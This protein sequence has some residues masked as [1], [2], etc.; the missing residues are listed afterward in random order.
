MTTET[1]V[2]QAKAD[3][4]MNKALGDLVG[5]YPAL[6]CSLGDRLGL[7]KD[8][9]ANGP[10]TSEELAARTGVQERYAREWLSALTCAGY[11]EYDPATSRFSLPPEHAPMLAEE[12]GPAFFGGAYAM[13]PIQMGMFEELATAFRVGGG[14]TQAAYGDAF[15]DSWQRFSA[16]WFEHL[17][18][19]VWLPALPGAQERL[20]QGCVLADV[21]CGQGRALI[22]LAQSFPRSRFVGYDTYQP[23]VAQATARAEGAGV[24]ERVS[25]IHLDAAQGLPEQYDVIATFDVV[26]DAADPRGLLRAIHGAL[27]PDGTYLCLEVNCADRLEDN[28]GPLGAA[29]YSSSLIYCMTTS[30]AAGGEGLGSMGLPESRLRELCL[31]AGF[32]SVRLVP[33]EN[34]FNNLYEI[35]P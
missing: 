21:G 32:S 5:A 17:L 14:I 1:I 8:L 16:G 28:I 13:F 15:Q 3:A 20:E 12:G 22:K 27:R 4:F 25:F 33:L 9:A 18:I 7:F 29:F 10:A 19:P 2:D 11:L 6:M 26:H 34:P 31:E 30:L 24:A 23:V 35:K